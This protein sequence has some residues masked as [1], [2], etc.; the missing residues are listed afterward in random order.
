DVRALPLPEA[1]G[2]E[3]PPGPTVRV[4]GRIMLRR[5]QGKIYFLEVRDW[6]ERIQI[7]IGMNQVG[8][9]GWNLAA[10]LDFGDLIGVD[11]TLGRTRTGE[12]TV[13]ATGLTF[14][15]KSLLPPPEKWHGLTDVEQRSRQRYVDLASNP[16]SLGVFLG[17]SKVIAAFRSVLAARGFVE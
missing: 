8:E 1:V 4:A 2:G 16:E 15:A 12:L 7:F 3:T 5:K 11:G 17:R 14:L 10:E 9:A 6:T 13:F